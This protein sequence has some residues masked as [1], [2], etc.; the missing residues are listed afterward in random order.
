M[1]ILVFLE[2]QQ[3]TLHRISREA[4]VAAQEFAREPGLSVAAFWLGTLPP[5]V[6]EELNA[7]GVAEWI[8]VSSP[9]LN[10]YSADGY[11]AA[12]CELIR[13]EQPRYIFMGHSYRVRDFV[14][15]VST[16]LNRPFISDVIHFAWKEQGP[17]F[18]KQ[19]FNAKM[20]TDMQAQGDGPVL[21][22][23]QAAAFSEEKLAAG[24]PAAREMTLDL[25]ADIVR[26]RAEEPFQEETGG[27]DL[28]AA[29]LIV[30]IGRGIGKKENIPLAQALADKMGA[31]LG[32]SRP[33]VDAGWMPPQRQ[34]GSSG[35]SVAPKLYF[36]LGISGAIQHVI[37]MK[38]SKNVV[39][40]NKD[41]EAP[42]FEIADYGVVG[43]ILE[44][45]PLLT[46]ALPG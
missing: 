28:T 15:R 14:P 19:I 44:L 12:F 22:S 26:S 34:V 33:L 29:D 40:I 32:S 11:T 43:D 16:R 38:G 3:G 21:V 35:Q 13:Q 42:I 30:S 8:Q 37:G 17:V 9:V 18:T 25:P 10:D 45:I 20:V 6:A 24:S 31:E 2:N 23:F 4:V 5:G 39:A 7:L 41:P 1:D 27:V 46:E 36:A